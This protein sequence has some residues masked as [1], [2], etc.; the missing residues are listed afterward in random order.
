MKGTEQS[1]GRRSTRRAPGPR[2]LDNMALME[3]PRGQWV[4]SRWL[5]FLAELG[6]DDQEGEEKPAPVVQ[7]VCPACKRPL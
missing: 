4:R 5:A 1:E 3:T 6:G 2:R 7:P